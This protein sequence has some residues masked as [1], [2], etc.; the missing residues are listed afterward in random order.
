MA[1]DQRAINITTC[2][3]DKIGRMFGALLFFRELTDKPILWQSS[4]RPRSSSATKAVS[5]TVARLAERSVQMQ[6]KSQDLL[7]EIR[8]N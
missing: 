6:G 7:R 1:S 4:N 5:S 8:S 3:A 2:V